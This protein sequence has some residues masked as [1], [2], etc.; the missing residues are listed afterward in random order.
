MTKYKINKQKC[1]GCGNCV[2]AC[3]QG[4]K[5]GPDGKSEVIDSEAA[6]KCGGIKICPF[7]AI[8]VAD[9]KESSSQ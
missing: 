7:G 9:Q 1:I 8:E 6:E 5:M 2:A 4:F 3:P